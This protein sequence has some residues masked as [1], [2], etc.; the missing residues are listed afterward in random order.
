MI[1][2]WCLLEFLL[3]NCWLVVAN[4]P[5]EKYFP[6]S[7][8]MMNFPRF[9]EEYMFQSTNQNSFGTCFDFYIS[10]HHEVSFMGGFHG[11]FRMNEFHAVPTDDSS[12]KPRGFPG[13]FFEG[14]HVNWSSLNHPWIFLWNQKT[15]IFF[16]E[17]WN[18]RC[19][20]QNTLWEYVN[21]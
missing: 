10:Y 13:D 14:S 3:I 21:Q 5:S 1:N 16:S 15:K 2:L 12:K 8:G 11:D 4:H 6:S 19:D 20:K 17:I 7:V 18:G 9:L